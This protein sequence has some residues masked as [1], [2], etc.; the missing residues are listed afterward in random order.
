MKARISQ[1][2]K[3]EAEWEK[4]NA[5][6]PEAGEFIIYD[7][8]DTYDYARLKIGDGDTPL[9]EL[10]FFIDSAALKVI[11][12]QRYFEVLDAGHVADRAINE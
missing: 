11:Q 4:L 12:K 9:G 3:T 7:S 6:A 8:D 2:H 5:W 10:P 1:L